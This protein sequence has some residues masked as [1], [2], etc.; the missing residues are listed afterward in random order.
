MPNGK[1]RDR[2]VPSQ[3]NV[4]FLRNLQETYFRRKLDE[5]IGSRRT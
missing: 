1:N 4:S 3:G 2:G 5:F